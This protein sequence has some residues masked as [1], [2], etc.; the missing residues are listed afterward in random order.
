MKK[1]FKI[2]IFKMQKKKKFKKKYLEVKK[3]LNFL[4]L[5]KLYKN[6]KI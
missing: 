6:K 1:K 3:N 5:I 2:N 4:I